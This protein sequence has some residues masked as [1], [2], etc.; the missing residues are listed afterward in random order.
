M[1]KST[2]DYTNDD[3]LLAVEILPPRPFFLHVTTVEPTASCQTGIMLV[4]FQ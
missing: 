4:Q 3:G 2:D 1:C